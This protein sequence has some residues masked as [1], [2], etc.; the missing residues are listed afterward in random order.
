MIKGYFFPTNAKDWYVDFSSERTLGVRDLNSE[1]RNGYINCMAEYIS[2][3][4]RVSVWQW[5]FSSPAPF[6]V[7]PAAHHGT[8]SLSV[9]DKKQLYWECLEVLPGVNS[10]TSEIL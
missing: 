3:A 4:Q 9:T 1:I 7:F 2:L 8:G 5:F 6:P 10:G